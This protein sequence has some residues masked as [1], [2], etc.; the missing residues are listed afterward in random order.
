MYTELKV[1]A[2]HNSGTWALTNEFSVDTT[3]DPSLGLMPML[4][5]IFT[6]YG[7]DATLVKKVMKPWMQNQRRTIYGQLLDG[8][9]HFDLR[10]CKQGSEYHACH[11]FIG[12]NYKEIFAQIKYFLM[13]HP[14]EFISLDFNHLY[15]VIH[16]DFIG[17]I[18]GT[19]GSMIIPKGKT[20]VPMGTL[21][22]RIFVFYDAVQD[23]FDRSN[24]INTFWANKQVM[25]ELVSS[26][27]SSQNSRTDLSK[28]YV[29]QF[30]LTPSLNDIVTGLVNG[31]PRSSE[32]LADEYYWR[33]PMII[34]S[35]FN[36]TLIGIVNTD[37]YNRHFV[38]VIIR[39]NY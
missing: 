32:E 6:Q 39:S 22:G 30:V 15:G 33:I 1:P 23:T 36:K 8:I 27:V 25:S 9:R 16:S 10:V 35:Q 17:M 11:G 12:P 34:E 14:G 29:S 38:D 26:V 18:V 2:T 21:A 3:M 37:F 28:L 13:A 4:G 20:N 19:F 24:S 5:P 31:F 7:L